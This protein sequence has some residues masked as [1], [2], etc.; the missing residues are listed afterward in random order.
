MLDVLKSIIKTITVQTNDNHFSLRR[1]VSRKLRM[2]KVK[3]FFFFA[4]KTI[5][6]HL[7]LLLSIDSNGTGAIY[8][9]DFWYLLAPE[10][11]LH[12]TSEMSVLF[13]FNRCSKVSVIY[14]IILDFA[15]SLLL[16]T[17]LAIWNMNKGMR[18]D[19]YEE[20]F[21]Q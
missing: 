18:W 21:R 16:E 12:K 11:T 9:S 4:L 3:L 15:I 20:F 14:I 2:W 13:E 8:T 1:I 19:K 17:N 5:S 10:Y 6:F 7:F